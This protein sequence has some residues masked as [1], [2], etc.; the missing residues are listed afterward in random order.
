[1]VIAVYADLKAYQSSDTDLY[2]IKSLLDNL[3]TTYPQENFYL[4]LPNPNDE[5]DEQLRL[6]KIYLNI[7]TGLFYKYRL[8]KKLSKFI[9]EIK[10]DL[11]FSIDA[12]PHTNILHALLLTGLNAHKK[13]QFAKLQ[14]LKS[15][16]VLSEVAK[17]EFLNENEIDQKKLSVIYGGPSKVFQP[18]YDEIK[19]FIK[20]KYTE[21]KE[22][23]IY[24]GLIKQQNNIIPLLKAF[25]LFKKRQKSSMKLVLLGRITWENNDFDKI[26]NTYKYREDVAVINDATVG[27]EPEILAAAYALIQPYTSNNLLF[28]F[29]AMQCHVPVLIENNPAFKEITSDAVL[30]FDSKSEMDIADKLM[31]IYK[32]ETLRNKLIEKGKNL[33][34]DYNWEKATEAVAKTFNN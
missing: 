30:Y 18:V 34:E 2:F 23:F 24:R 33:I 13:N 9:A 28:L 1:M 7:S 26:I 8:N 21:G 3:V 25:S 17:T 5:P 16:F 31:L 6:S 12:T 20:E 22:Y 15:I 14:D 10:A 11:L 27:E 29:D 4:I 19:T 32:D